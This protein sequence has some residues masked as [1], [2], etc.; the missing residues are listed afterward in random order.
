VAAWFGIRYWRGYDTK[1]RCRDTFVLLPEK[2]SWKIQKKKQCMDRL[3]A[4]DEY[5]HL[6]RTYEPLRSESMYIRK[7]S[8]D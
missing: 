8:D 5:H 2:D 1:G 4:S 6:S 3:R 7:L